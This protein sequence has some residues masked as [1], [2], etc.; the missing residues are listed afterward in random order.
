MRTNLF[1]VSL[2]TFSSH[3]QSCS[4]NKQTSVSTKRKRKH[5]GVCSGDFF[6]LAC[7][8]LPVWALRKQSKLDFNSRDRRWKRWMSNRGESK[9]RGREAWQAAALVGVGG[10]WSFFMFYCTPLSLLHFTLCCG[11]VFVLSLLL[12]FLAPVSKKPIPVL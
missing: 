12:L 11:C 9:E 4:F 10:V 5:L 2:I 1:S 6:Y 7:Y 8:H 3:L